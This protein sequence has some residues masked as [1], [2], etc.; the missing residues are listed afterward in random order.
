MIADDHLWYRYGLARAIESDPRLC[1]AAVAHDG[2]TALALIEE[3]EPD[4]A[5]LDLS[6]PGLDGISVC[7]RA[8]SRRPPL[9]TRVIVL[10][11]YLDPPLAIAA[12][13]AGAW[14][15]LERDASRAEICHSVLAVA[16][17]EAAFPTRK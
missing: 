14:G 1:L 8:T 3:L 10:S 9:R 16:N 17:G 6:M 5:L 4:V 13:D 15:Y 11:A 12:A 7:A 2:P